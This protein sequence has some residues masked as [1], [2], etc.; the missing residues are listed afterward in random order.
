MTSPTPST[1]TT[2]H[3]VGLTPTG[4]VP[5]GSHRPLVPLTRMLAGPTLRD[6]GSWALPVVAFA[7]IATITLDVCAG[8]VV[9]WTIPGDFTLLY[10]GLA[11]LAVVLLV[12][13]L[14]TLASSAARLAARRRDDRLASLRLLGARSTTLRHLTLVESG[15]Q[16]LAGALLGLVGY[17]LSVPLL[18]L[19][20]FGGQAVGMRPLLL[21]P[22][23]LALIVVALV[24]L[25][26]LSSAVGLHRVEVHPLGVRMRQE[27]GR[28]SVVRL[29]IGGVV[30]TV[31]VGAAATVTRIGAG[32]LPVAVASGV[33]V[34]AIGAAMVVADIVGPR[35][36]ATH[37]RRMLRRARTAEQLVAAR[38]V[39]ES[40]KRAWRQV[41]SLGSV[42]FV[43]VAGGSG[44]A[45]LSRAQT[46]TDTPV[47]AVHLVHDI[48]LGIALTIGFAFA[49]V[50]CSVGVNQAAAVLD[51]REVEVG[52]DVLGM[53][54]DRQETA[55]RRAVLGPLWF[56]MASSILTASLVLSPVVGAGLLLSPMTMLVMA[57]VIAGGAGL[58]WLGIRLTRPTLAGVLRDGLAR[59]D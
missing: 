25:A 32:Y 35:L 27:A 5:T 37:F 9:I 51:R 53:T 41:S 18:G 10:R 29:V 31:A 38:M 43:G 57:G 49:T 22:W 2:G 16:A 58:V 24:T 21:A 44:V 20:H 6:R 17:G 50:A 59:L 8:A 52:L 3:P 47:E 28:A 39:L 19:L 15:S 34:A 42:C 55:R 45:L 4:P 11:G 7:V 30:L 40:P 48:G 13:P 14:V 33:V 1:S 46:S 12:L 23:W 36:L 56:V 26:L 54:L